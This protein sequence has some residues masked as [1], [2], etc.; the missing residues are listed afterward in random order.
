[1]K[2]IPLTQ[3]K[4]ALVDDRDYVN[5]MAIG[6][7]HA[8]KGRNTWYAVRAFR[9]RSGKICRWGMHAVLLGVRGTKTVVD[10][11]NGN[12][13]DNRRA[14]LRRASQAQNQINRAGN[15]RS[16]SMASKYRGVKL[17]RARTWEADIRI[18][19]KKTFLGSFKTA[20]DAARAYDA[21]ARQY[22]GEFAR[23]NFP[24]E[25]DTQDGRPLPSA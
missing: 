15:L 17:R 18:N 16:G 3:G 6:P 24:A 21:A 23:L 13:L 14:N 10:H 7:W 25:S 5:L 4:V 11:R 12:G 22:H 20:E 19:G 1:M 9:D 8:A 2:E